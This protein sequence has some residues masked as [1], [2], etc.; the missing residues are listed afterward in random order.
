[1]ARQAPQLASSSLSRSLKELS[2]GL[3]SRA[4]LGDIY[5]LARRARGINMDHLRPR[6][7]S[8]RFSAIYRNGTWLASDGSGPLSGL[9]SSLAATAKVRAEL[10]V[11][12]SKLRTRVLLDIGCGDFNWMQNVDL[13]CAYIGVD[14]VPDLVEQNALRYGGRREFLLLDATA[15]ELPSADSVLCREVLFHLSFSDAQRI[16]RN[17]KSSGAQFLIA[18]NDRGLRFNSDVTSGDFRLLNLCKP[19]FRFPQP[20]LSIADDSVNRD[21]I[22]GVWNISDLAL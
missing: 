1:M 2:R 10:P 19:P 16:L 20:I 21:R 14:I 3:M 4:G 8:E 5:T 15:A 6:E 11:L 9:G 17:I 7:L 18:T 13:P 12:L 22:M